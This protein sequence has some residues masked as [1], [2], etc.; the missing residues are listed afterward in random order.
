MEKYKDKIDTV[1]VTGHSLGS[2]LATLAALD[3]AQVIKENNWTTKTT[4]DLIKTRGA[5]Y[6]NPLVGG[7]NLE[8]ALDELDVTLI[9]YIERG[10]IVPLGPPSIWFPSYKRLSNTYR[11][12]PLRVFFGQK[13]SLVNQIIHLQILG[14]FEPFKYVIGLVNP[15]ALKRRQGYLL[16][17]YKLDDFWKPWLS[18]LKDVGSFA[19]DWHN[20]QVVM[21]CLA[22]TRGLHRDLDLIN[23][24]SGLVNENKR[25][26]P[27]NWFTPLK[28]KGVAWNVSGDPPKLFTELDHT[29][30]ADIRVPK[31]VD[32]HG[33]DH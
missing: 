30:A 3:A 7:R 9:N 6:C 24:S 10:D 19:G 25:H 29:D 32:S 14:F 28:H 12:D 4:G 5:V 1:T 2:S 27:E 8:N 11:L 33:H 17:E 21:Y 15:D 16:K 23:K 31:I 18:D 20:L 13:Q 26:V 22:A